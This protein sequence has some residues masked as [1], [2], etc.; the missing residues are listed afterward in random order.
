MTPLN[1]QVVASDDSVL[2]SLSKSP[3][4]LN[5]SYEQLV[6]DAFRRKWWDSKLAIRINP[7]N[8]RR[9]FIR[10]F[11]PNQVEDTGFFAIGVRPSGE[12]VGLAGKD[13]FDNSFS[14]ATLALEG[15]FKT[16][17]GEEPPLVPDSP[18]DIVANGAFKTPGL[19]NVEL[20][21]PYF[22][23]GGQSTLEQVG[24]WG[25]QRLGDWERGRLGEAEIGRLGDW[26]TR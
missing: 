15:K 12:D 22:H 24:D 6:Q 18:Q 4:S 14:E 3:T 1:K 8:G 7:D 16:L 5:K 19:R 26:E 23:N 21:A 9:R 17:L 10:I 13:E 2:G 11:P 25:R 20:T